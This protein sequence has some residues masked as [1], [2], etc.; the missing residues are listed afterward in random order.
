M[1]GLDSPVGQVQIVK[2]EK[3]KIHPQSTKIRNSDPA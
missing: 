3:G 2:I 1:D